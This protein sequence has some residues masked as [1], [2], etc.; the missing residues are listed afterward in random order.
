MASQYLSKAAQKA[1]NAAQK[2][3]VKV[4]RAG[5]TPTITPP[6]HPAEVDVVLYFDE[7]HGLTTQNVTDRTKQGLASNDTATAYQTLCWALNNLRGGEKPDDQV[8]LVALFLSTT[9]DIANCPPSNSRHWPAC[10][11]LHPPV[12]ELPFDLWKTEHIVVEGTHMIEDV[13]R[14]EFMVRFG[15]PL[16]WTRWEVGDRMVQNYI[17]DFAQSKLICSDD[18][19]TLS[20][21]AEIAVLARRLLLDF[22]PKRA[23]ALWIETELVVGHMHVAYSVPAHREYLRAGAPSEPILAEATARIM[24]SDDFETA[25]NLSWCLS[26][27]WITRGTR[28]ELVGGLL[29]IQATAIPVIDFLASLFPES[30]EKMF[31]D[32]T[33]DNTHGATLKEAFQNAVVYFTHWGKGEDSSFINDNAGWMAI[34]RGMAIQCHDYEDDIDFVI[35]VL[36]DHR[37]TLSRFDMSAILIQLNIRDKVQAANMSA[38]ALHYF[39]SGNREQNSRPYI[40]IIMELGLKRQPPFAKP[41]SIGYSAPAKK[42]KRVTHPRYSFLVTGCS[43]SVYRVIPRNQ[44]H[45]YKGLLASDSLLEEH[46]RPNEDHLDAVLQMK[47]DWTTESFRWVKSSKPDLEMESDFQTDELDER[48]M[49]GPFADSS[50]END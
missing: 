20:L 50:E 31:C 22:E 25:K 40:T 11:H 13:C 7:S 19:S 34:C 41:K 21:R 9:F 33:P 38:S 23:A 12:V 30:Y 49:A 8:K 16:F 26:G 29:L 6:N 36:Y 37:Q 47:P 48:I 39:T 28:G 27:R 24:A 43:E 17:I 3:I 4:R 35:P 2:L 44:R 1:L 15:R 14:P 10:T 18:L 32:A 45:I 42:A 46:P 5:N